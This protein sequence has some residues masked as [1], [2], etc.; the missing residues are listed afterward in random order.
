LGGKNTTDAAQFSR[1]KIQHGKRL[2]DKDKDHDYASSLPDAVRLSRGVHVITS[3]FRGSYENRRFSEILA[4]LAAN[5]ENP[6]VE[7]VHTLWEKENPAQYF[8]QYPKLLAK[9]VPSEVKRQ[10][11]YA[12]LFNYANTVLQRGSVA[13]ITNAGWWWSFISFLR[14]KMC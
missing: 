4:T 13:I 10:P 11:T 2:I 1:K 8:S 12:V 7:Y 5:L 14:K 9:L 6:H 3:F